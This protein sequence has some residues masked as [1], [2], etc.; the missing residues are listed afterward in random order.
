MMVSRAPIIGRLNSRCIRTNTPVTIV[1]S[2]N[3]ARTAPGAKD[4]SKRKE[5]GRKEFYLYF[6][7]KKTVGLGLL[8]SRVAICSL[9]LW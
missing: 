3:R 4:R 5:Q 1:T 9:Y 7:E 8:V 2:W 6:A